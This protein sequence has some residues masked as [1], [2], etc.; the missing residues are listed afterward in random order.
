MIFTIT[1]MITFIMI[2]IMIVSFLMQLFTHMYSPFIY[3]FVGI[4]APTSYICI[5][6]MK[7]F[8]EV[9]LES[10]CTYSSW[11]TFWHSIRFCVTC[12][13]GTVPCFLCKI[14]KGTVRRKLRGVQIVRYLPYL[15]IHRLVGIVFF[16]QCR[17]FFLF[18][19]KG[20]HLG[21]CITNH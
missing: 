21:F 1:M 11:S 6:A 20:H 8:F 3:C 5:F 9:F 13:Y 2:V 16:L 18:S 10:S 15:P 7:R 19:L 12:P 4:C 17:R 14:I